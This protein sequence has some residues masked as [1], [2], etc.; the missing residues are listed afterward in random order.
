MG[1]PDEHRELLL[2]FQHTLD[3]AEGVIEQVRRL[4]LVLEG[5]LQATPE[6]LATVKAEEAKWRAHIE[7]QRM[8]LASFAVEPPKAMH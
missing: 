1:H 2:A 6:D 8:R 3:L 5:E 7:G 4:R